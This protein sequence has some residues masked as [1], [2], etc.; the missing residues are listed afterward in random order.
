MQDVQNELQYIGINSLVI[1]DTTKKKVKSHGEGR[2][3]IYTGNPEEDAYSLSE[4]LSDN[5]IMPYYVEILFYKHRTYCSSS[6]CSLEDM[7]GWNIGKV[8]LKCS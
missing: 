3:M 2:D 7:R 8:G 4:F 5:M 1:L 6:D